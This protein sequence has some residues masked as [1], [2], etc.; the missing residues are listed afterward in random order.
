M[1]SNIDGGKFSSKHL[2]VKFCLVSKTKGKFDMHY[3]DDQKF[4]M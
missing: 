1:I 4:Q 2:G 3:V